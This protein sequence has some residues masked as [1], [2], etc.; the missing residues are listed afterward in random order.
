MRVDEF[1]TD[2]RKQ[3][4]IVKVH[5]GQLAVH[6]NGD[7]LTQNIVSALKAHK[8][9][10][11]SFF[12]KLKDK[13]SFVSI[14]QAPSLDYYPLTSAQS[15]IYFLYEFDKLSTTYN[16]PAVFEIEGEVNLFHLNKIFN[17][18]INRHQSLRTN[19][20]IGN[21]GIVQKVKQEFHFEIIVKSIIDSEID[22]NINAFIRPFDLSNELPI[23]VGLFKISSNRHILI[24]DMHHIICDGH[25]ID[26]LLYDFLSLYQG[27][28]LAPLSLQYVDYAHWQQSESFELKIEHSKSYWQDLYS[29]E[30]SEL[31]LPYDRPRP[32]FRHNEGIIHRVSISDTHVSSLR[33]LS[34]DLGVTLS[35]IF[36]SI[37]NVLLYKIS[38]NNDVIVGTATSGRQHAD[39]DGIV[40][41]FVNTLALRNQVNPKEKFNSFVAN[42]HKNTML[43][44]EHQMY[45]Y[46]D[47]VDLL[48]IERDTSR[49]PIFDVFYLYTEQAS[50]S[51]LDS[52]S[53]IKVYKGHRQI[54]SK[55]DLSLN[56]I[57]SKSNVSFEFEA[58]KDLFDSST[59][60]RLTEYFNLLISQVL[61]N[62]SQE[63]STLSILPNSEK[64]LLLNKFNS[65][66][67]PY[68]LSRTILDY[69]I[70]HVESRPHEIALSFN[71]I[72]LSFVELN[73]NSNKW[74]SC[75]TSKGITKKSVVALLMDRSFDM[76]TAIFSIFKIG[77]AYMPIS[78][79]APEVR[80]IHMLSEMFSEFG[81]NVVLT[82]AKDLSQTILDNYSVV[83]VSELNNFSVTKSELSDSSSSFHGQIDAS[84][85]AYVIYTSGST[86]LPKGVC[87]T[88]RGLMNRLIW[89]HD[90]L[91]L[92]PR[93]TLV[94]KTP[95]TFD[96]S[97]W[98]LLMFAF[99]GC[100]LE[101]LK[102]DGHKDPEYIQK[103]LFETKVELIHFVP[104][105][106][107]TFLDAVSPE[108]C[109]NLKQ[110]VCSGESL[111]SE[112]VEKCKSVLPWVAIYNFYGP[113]EAAIDVTSIDLTNIPTKDR[114]VSIGMPVAN[115]QIYIVNNEN[116]IQPLGIQGELLIGGVQVAN[117]YVNRRALTEERFIPNPF[118]ENDHYKLYRTGDFA[119]WNLDG[120]ISYIGRMDHQVKL[121]GV[122]IEPGEIERHL[123]DF[124]LVNNAAI[125]VQEIDGVQHLVAYYISKKELSKDILRDYLFERLPLS[126]IPSYYVQLDEFPNTSSGKLDRKSLPLPG[127][128]KESYV[129]PEGD[130]ESRLVEI[131]SN[132]LNQNSGKIGVT[133]GFFELGGNSLKAMMLINSINKEF[134][135]QL[136]IRDIFQHQT[137]RSLATLISSNENHDYVSIPRADKRE[138]YPLSTAQ[139]RMYFLYELD[140]T[141][142][143]YNIPG[144]FEISEEVEVSRLEPI[145]YQL[146]K[147]HESLRTVFDLK[148]EGASQR[149]ID[150]FKFNISVENI[151][152]SEVNLALQ[153]CIRPFDLA[154]EIPFRVSLLD[155]EFGTSLLV[156]DMHHIV[157][158]GVSMKTLLS[159]F[160]RL[161]QGYKLSPLALQYTDFAIWQQSD[162]YKQLISEAQEYW[163]G[164]YQDELSELMLPYDYS[165]TSY[166]SD[167]AISYKFSLSA[168][169]VVGLQQI[170]NENNVT[171]SSLFLSVLL[172][173]L[174]K[175]SGNEDI[176]VGTATAGRLHADLENMVGMFVNTLALRNNLKASESF[177]TIVSKVHDT[178]MSA[179]DNQ[180]YQY[181]DLIDLIGLERNTSRN[182][183]FDVF[184]LFTEQSS[185]SSTDSPIKPYQGKTHLTSKFD[186]SM[187]VLSSQDGID[188]EFLARKDLFKESSIARFSSFIIMI[189]DQVLSDTKQN[190][191]EL[192][193]LSNSTRKLILEDFNSTDCTFDFSDT[194][195]DIFLNQVTLNSLNDALIYNGETLSYSELNERSDQWGSYLTD[196]NVSK[197]SVIGLL[198]H[199]SSDMIT[200]IITSFKLGCAFLPMD[201]MQP[202]LRSLHMASESGACVLLSNMKKVPSELEEELTIIDV[203]DLNQ[204]DK[205]FINYNYPSSSDIAYIMYTSGSTGNSKGCLISHKNLYN[206]ISWCNSFYFNDNAEGNFGLMTSMVF[207]LSMTAIF[208]S[209]TRGRKLYIGDDQKNVIQLLEQMFNN[210]DIDSIK[211]TPTHI[212][213][214]DEI[215]LN[216]TGIR[217]IICGGEPLK[218][219]HVE[220]LKGINENIRIYN[221]YGPTEATVGC[222]VSE[223]TLDK[224]ISI[225]KPTANTQVYIVNE[226]NQI[227]PIGIQGE[228]LIGGLQ[229]SEGYL[230]RPDLTSEKFIQSIDKITCSSNLYRT[231]DLCSWN[232]D[233]TI[234]YY[235][236]I[237]EQVKINGIRIEPGEIECH[238][239]EIDEI[240]DSFVTVIEINNTEYLSAYYTSFNKISNDRL[241]SYLF[242]RLPINL[243]PTYFVQ[244]DLFPLTRN[245][246]LDRKQ[247]PIPTVNHDVLILPDS[248][249][250]EKLLNLWEV[251]LDKN[252]SE[253]GVSKSF[254]E[255][256]GN[257]LKAMI[258]MNRVNEEFS[259]QLSLRDIFRFQT[260]RLLSAE[261]INRD[262]NDTSD[263]L[264]I[265]L[266]STTATD[267]I[268]MIHDGS[269]EVD[270]YLEL[271]RLLPG[272]NCYGIRYSSHF[273][274]FPEAL[275]IKEISESY[276]KAIKSIQPEGPY[277]F[278]GWSLGGVIGS[279]ITS[280]LEKRGERIE[281]L[282]V[283]DSVYN[284][285]RPKSQS[286][287]NIASE[288]ELL[289]TINTSLDMDLE[290]FKNINEVWQ[291]VLN[292][293]E[294]QN[295]SLEQVRSLISENYR[296]LIPGFKSRT[297]LELVIAFNKIRL[298]L[299]ASDNYYLSSSIDSKTIYVQASSSDTSLSK[300]N[301]AFKD[302]EYHVI[303]GDHFSIMQ[304]PQVEL[305]SKLIVSELPI[306]AN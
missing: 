102:P 47:L 272:H 286:V 172:I 26:V 263:Q 280:Q 298:L 65:T 171:V 119:K 240:S 157:S 73:I 251:I 246:K 224:E 85:I 239:N 269:G 110:I 92:S 11:I 306:F 20:D 122:R 206:Y 212:S 192:T 270:G 120:T 276:I 178:V 34:S 106:L 244:L 133:Y 86:G 209:L 249:M 283:I 67:Q 80:S 158:D 197:G 30:V 123:K 293:E 254:F 3:N 215:N 191:K 112:L 152:E 230:N 241:R 303:D 166:R 95:Y 159:D 124:N 24:V 229:V 274:H 202:I 22:D 268:F 261:I 25:S 228:L 164:I 89:M 225:G 184:Y 210:L 193:I 208:T 292:S 238:L 296:R 81:N 69:F 132:I 64:N 260:V 50:L 21:A 40:G 160:W 287:I 267:N 291:K 58:R 213:L 46:E 165:R 201:P 271:A 265:P 143:T 99:T 236:R 217:T 96:V 88:H 63:I 105:M 295:V 37:Y 116:Q 118:N 200:A 148:N 57:V 51:S 71:G 7:A 91:D 282:L 137:I 136:L 74:A 145:F 35:T 181:E 121:N 302:I 258:L 161:Y 60:V 189:I 146:I 227:Q 75:L 242:D 52:S 33:K 134:S 233:G 43:A 16:I 4:I 234:T 262:F 177:E 205:R 162:E 176:V 294:F 203:S 245:G 5:D 288:I 188:I 235:G 216:Q 76:V 15:R 127:I 207:D 140:K 199:R 48:G 1:I 275:N 61:L 103:L 23:R 300:L 36:L 87:N 93:S 55:F 179:L 2:L 78:T 56:V 38:G 297:A 223:I 154:T 194:V 281:C 27:H 77:C 237:D 211:L 114:G 12:T 256:G 226:S 28:E 68:D 144:V 62:A 278:I 53:P 214:L 284:F 41:M 142:T 125:M 10:I 70:G 196:Q 45:Q 255:L 109:K 259:V 190:L 8:D 204:H 9:D 42:I 79:T 98:E 6:D 305:I 187:E 49:N 299:N 147:H 220:I 155:V 131:W 163:K 44:L 219:R 31:T 252:L 273:N 186:L 97:V 17:D 149:V 107:R 250:E 108:K 169:Q 82:N 150:D 113:T 130:I 84:D 129:N 198:M 18:L 151:A 117:G 115:T 222:T 90:L 111:P 290:D 66:A 39:L 94:Q 32:L 14:E 156:V 289:R 180:L 279:E 168:T 218:K 141:S 101:I 126:M 185:V 221:E 139:H 83:T 153:N 175:V 231:G 264:I 135:V 285:E 174:H 72:G 253:Y 248:E 247:L 301:S 138:S 29:Q 19:F 257:S 167:R 13:G 104:S 54:T 128:E 59:L 277:R 243:I 173:M 195:L 232:E 100:R 170:S 183:I 182:P 304:A 266:N